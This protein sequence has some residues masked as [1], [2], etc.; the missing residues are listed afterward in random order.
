LGLIG[1]IWYVSLHGAINQLSGHKLSAAG[2][3]AFAMRGAGCTVNDM[4]DRDFDGK[5]A[6]TA[7][8]P[9]A[10]G[11]ITMPKALVFLGA[12]LSAALGVLLQLNLNTIA[13]G[14]AAVPLV[15]CY[16]LMKRITFL[17]QLI[18]GFAMNYG[19]LM[20]WSAVH[21]TLDIASVLPLYLGSVGWTVVYDTLYAHQDKEDDAKLGLKSAALL[22]G[23]RTKEVLSGI[24]VASGAAF[25]LTGV[26]AELAWPF[27]LGPAAGTAHMLWQ[28][29]TAD[30]EDRL[31]LT[32]RF[33]S[34]QWI[35][36]G[37]LAALIAGRMLQ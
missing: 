19:I 20:G 14:C 34:N 29:R 27:Y 5:V 13:L 8:R 4:W 22:M 12:Q 15:V 33:V 11:K 9:L 23:D 7:Q 35:G 30:Y 6:R 31:G 26:V 28:V 36:W 1:V 25:C 16:P 21:G 17:P 32:K 2:V 18:L 24:A 37:M 3:G 10:S